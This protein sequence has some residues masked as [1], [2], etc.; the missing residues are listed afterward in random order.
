MKG[1][2]QGWLRVCVAGGKA[3]GMAKALCGCKKLDSDGQGSVW[4]DAAMR[5]DGT[6][7]C[8]VSFQTF[9]SVKSNTV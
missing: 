7:F 8:S 1:T 6:A 9:Q 5:R 4:L 3:T 2:L